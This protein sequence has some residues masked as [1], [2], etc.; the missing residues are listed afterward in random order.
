MARLIELLLITQLKTI[1]SMKIC[2]SRTRIF[3][4]L[5]VSPAILLG[6][7]RT[8]KNEAD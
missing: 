4:I 2:K 8:R 1:I 7:R 6:A 3:R 5:E